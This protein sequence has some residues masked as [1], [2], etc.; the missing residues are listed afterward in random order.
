[1]FTPIAHV[2]NEKAQQL[3]QLNLKREMHEKCIQLGL[4]EKQNRKQLQQTNEDLKTISKKLKK[5]K[6]DAA[7]QKN[8]GTQKGRH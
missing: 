4:D 1:M 2:Q 3:I 8:I 5:L 7:R 6:D